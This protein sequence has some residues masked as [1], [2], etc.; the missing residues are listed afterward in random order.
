MDLNEKCILVVGGSGVLGGELVKILSTKGARVLATARTAETAQHIPD[1]AQLKLLVDLGDSAS[2]RVLTDYLSANEPID[3]IILAAGRV[4]FGVAAETSEGDVSTLTQVNFLGQA[5]LLTA[6]TQS[7]KGRED[8][9]VAAITGV[10]AEKSFP[11][12]SAYSAS[13]SALSAWLGSVA[14]E[15]RRDKI[16]VMDL[17]PGHTETGLATRPLFGNAPQMP[18]GMSPEHVA[19]AIVSAIESGATVVSSAEF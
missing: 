12:M 17:R 16:R 3:G 11:G 6:L 13:K 7:L 14:M 15:W 1:Q 18:T 8:A 19:Q 5:Q 9:F 2:I 10:V 4:G